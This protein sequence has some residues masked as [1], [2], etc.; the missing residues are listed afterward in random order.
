MAN[1]YRYYIR[2]S[3]A[4]T[5]SKEIPIAFHGSA[6]NKRQLFYTSIGWKY[7]PGTFD[8]FEST[9]T[10]KVNSSSFHTDTGEQRISSTGKNFANLFKK[11]NVTIKFE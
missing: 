10:G 1:F 3:L 7:T 2:A 5:Y 6:N 9:S 4:I 11:Y 8:L